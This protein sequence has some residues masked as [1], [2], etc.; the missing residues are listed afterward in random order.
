[1]TILLE[2]E[3]ASQLLGERARIAANEGVNVSL[4]SLATKAMRAG[5]ES[6]GKS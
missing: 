2:A 4:T 3:L 5:F 1:M 6:M